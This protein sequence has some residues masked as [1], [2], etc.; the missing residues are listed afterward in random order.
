M[1]TWHSDPL[2]VIKFRMWIQDY[3][4]TFLNI[5]KSNLRY[6]LASVIQ[7]SGDFSQ[8]HVCIPPVGPSE[9]LLVVG[10]TKCMKTT[11]TFNFA[12]HYISNRL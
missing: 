9:T 7:W 5:I 11:V 1:Y 4:S 3:F 2:E 10:H 6:V 8:L 12:G